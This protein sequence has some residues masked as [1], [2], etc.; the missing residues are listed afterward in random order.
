MAPLR[1]LCLLLALTPL[2]AQPL[3][4][5][6]D[7]LTVYY[8]PQDEVAAGV[9][10]DAA[11]SG[12]PILE[13]ALGLHYSRASDRRQIR[14]DIVRSQD[15]FNRLVGTT[16]KPWVQGAA[17][18]GQRRIVL[19]S[20]LPQTLRLVTVHELTHVLLDELATELHADPPRWLHEGLAKYAADDFSEGDREVLGQAVVQRRLLTIAQV[21][22]AFQGK[23]EQVELAYAQSYTL[24]DY[25]HGLRS[26]GGLKQFLG[27]LALTGDT[28]RALLRTY[29]RTRPEIETAWHQKIQ[30]M[31]LSHGLPFFT[32]GIILLIMG[33]LFLIVHGVNTRRRRLIRERLQEEER[34]RRMFL[35]DDRSHHDS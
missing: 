4:R 20:L 13:S 19:K 2:W 29:G 3:G 27:E 21:E 24:V 28:D 10:L 31:Y 25:L 8:S 5:S 17:L 26:D 33:V 22:Q 12:L 16:M 35:L 7:S 6:R 32:E 11:S 30:E 14:I 34:L 9:V 15:E 23:R 1:Y 18:G